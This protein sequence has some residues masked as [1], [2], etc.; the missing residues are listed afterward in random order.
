MFG[1]QFQLVFQFV[2]KLEVE[3]HVALPAK[4]VLEAERKSSRTKATRKV[5]RTAPPGFEPETDR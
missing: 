2:F 4:S 5:L 3:S 1:V